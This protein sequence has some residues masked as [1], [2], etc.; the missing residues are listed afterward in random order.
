M[1][2]ERSRGGDGIDQA[3]LNHIADDQV[4]LT[5]RHRAG[6]RKEAKTLFIA[7]HGAQSFS[8]FGDL[9]CDAAIGREIRHERG[10]RSSPPVDP[11]VQAPVENR[12]NIARVGEHGVGEVAV[13]DLAGTRHVEWIDKDRARGFPIDRFGISF[14]ECSDDDSV[15]SPLLLPYVLRGEHNPVTPLVFDK[16]LQ[17]PSQWRIFQSAVD[18]NRFFLR[19]DHCLDRAGNLAEHPGAEGAVLHPVH[20]VA[21]GSALF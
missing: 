10:Y 5:D 4:H 6:Y 1:R 18:E 13:S 3:G 9:R 8:S 7:H 19:G 17:Q 11:F 15:L 2:H 20:D 12:H 14:G 21:D 16:F